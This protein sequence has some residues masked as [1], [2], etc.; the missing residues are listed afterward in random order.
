MDR[1]PI[2]IAGLLGFQS[3]DH[4]RP[5]QDESAEEEPCS[6]VLFANLESPRIIHG[7]WCAKSKDDGSDRR[8]AI[9]P[10]VPKKTLRS[11]LSSHRTTLTLTLDH[12]HASMSLKILVRQ[13]V[14]S[15]D[16]DGLDSPEY[17]DILNWSLSRVLE[18]GKSYL[19]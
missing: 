8:T 1:T 11:A 16:H 7:H 3:L 13:R 6:V 19:D 10:S 18:C 2:G 5:F 14:A 17:V 4:A 12:G 15:L 9:E